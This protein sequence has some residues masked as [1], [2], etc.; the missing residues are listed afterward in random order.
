MSRTIRVM[1]NRELEKG[2]DTRAAIAEA[3]RCLL[4]IS[5]GFHADAI[6]ISY[7]L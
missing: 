7:T 6:E 1:E 4:C 3:S 2:F 5:A